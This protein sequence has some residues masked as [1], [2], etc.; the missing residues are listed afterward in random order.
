LP[1]LAIGQEERLPNLAVGVA[2]KGE[3]EG[4]GKGEGEGK[5]EIR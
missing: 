4:K 2:R 1:H 5:G 3:G